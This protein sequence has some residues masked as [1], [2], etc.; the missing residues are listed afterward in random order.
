MELTVER[1]RAILHYD[2]ETGEFRWLQRAKSRRAKVGNTS[3][4]RHTI[5]RITIDRKQYKGHRLA[6]FYMTG[7]WPE[8]IDHKDRNSLNNRW[9]NFR[10]ATRSQNQWNHKK[11]KNNTSGVTGLIW[12]KLGSRWVVRFRGKHFGSFSDKTEAMRIAELHR[13]DFAEIADRRPPRT[14]ADR[15]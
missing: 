3:K 7:E 15:C 8:R 10:V 12:D 11:Y 9:S 14:W 4:Q 1:L 13:K 2:P 6:W 5:L